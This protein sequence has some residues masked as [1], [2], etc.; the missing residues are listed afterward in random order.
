MVEEA[1]LTTRPIHNVM[2]LLAPAYHLL[3][4]PGGAKLQ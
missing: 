3:D 4:P 2:A 1:A